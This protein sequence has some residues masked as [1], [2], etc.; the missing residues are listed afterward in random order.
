MPSGLSCVRTSAGHGRRRARRPRT[1]MDV[2]CLGRPPGRPPGPSTRDPSAWTICHGPTTRDRSL[3]AVR[4]TETLEPHTYWSR[5]P[6]Q[7]CDTILE[8]TSDVLQHRLL[9]NLLKE[10]FLRY[11]AIGCEVF[12]Y[13]HYG[14][15]LKIGDT[16]L[17]S[18]LVHLWVMFDETYT[19]QRVI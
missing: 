12:Q 10:I 8:C 19:F 4:P 1:P 6:I 9:K 3:G 13:S 11:S 7:A 5:S 16:G 14:N 18:F 15:I 17:T 2:C